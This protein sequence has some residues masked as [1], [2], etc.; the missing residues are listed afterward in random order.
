MGE[1]C[2]LPQRGLEPQPKSNL[3]HFSLKIWHLVGRVLIIF[4]VVVVEV[5]CVLCR[6]WWKWLASRVLPASRRSSTHQHITRDL[7][8]SIQPS[9]P[10]ASK[11][12]KAWTVRA[13]VPKNLKIRIYKLQHPGLKSGLEMEAVWSPSLPFLSLCPLPSLK[14]S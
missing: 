1:R 3:V 9:L 8:S 14:S 10:L 4:L 5:C 11:H 2:K 7:T 6:S 12:R 13:R